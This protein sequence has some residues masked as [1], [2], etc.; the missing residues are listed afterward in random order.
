M[1]KQNVV[2]KDNGILFRLKKEGSSDTY[3]SMDK[4]QEY[5]AE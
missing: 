1:D 2:Y 3:Y 4:F 5:Y